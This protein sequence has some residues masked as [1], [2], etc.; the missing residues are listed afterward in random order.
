M[1]KEIIL[2]GERIINAGPGVDQMTGQSIVSITLD[3]SGA[4][5]FKQV[6]NTD[7]LIARYKKELEKLK[8]IHKITKSEKTRAILRCS[9]I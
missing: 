7:V 1:K 4:N 2:T 3:G 5:I 8:Q 6:N 9:I